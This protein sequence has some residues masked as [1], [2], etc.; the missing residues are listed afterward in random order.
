M[1]FDQSVKIWNLN[2][3]AQP[4][5]ELEVRIWVFFRVFFIESIKL[6]IN[7]RFMLEQL[8]E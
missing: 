2:D 3:P 1:A 8:D 6:F 5:M 4:Q 7:K